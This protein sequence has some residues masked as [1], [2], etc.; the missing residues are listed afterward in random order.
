MWRISKVNVHR[1]AITLSA[2]PPLIEPQLNVISG[3]PVG[4]YFCCNSSIT[5]SKRRKE[6]FHAL[7]S[8]EALAAARRDGAEGLRRYAHEKFPELRG[9]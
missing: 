1:S 8:D 4:V 5:D 6:L 9:G 3:S 2:E 7:A